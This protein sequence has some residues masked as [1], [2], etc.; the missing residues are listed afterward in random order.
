MSTATDRGRSSVRKAREVAAPTPRGFVA[1][2]PDAKPAKEKS[3]TAKTPI[4]LLVMPA[5]L[6]Q[7]DVVA[8]RRG[9]SRSALLSY[10]IADGLA[11]DAA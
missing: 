5:I 10:W 8:K 1:G 6:E 3:T 2:A 11:K 4:T 9:M 7:V